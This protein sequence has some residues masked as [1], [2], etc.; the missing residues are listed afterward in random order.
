[1]CDVEW[2]ISPQTELRVANQNLTPA[3]LADRG[4]CFL[5]QG[6]NRESLQDPW[7]LCLAGLMEPH[8]LPK[9]C[10]VVVQLAWPYIYQRMLRAYNVLDPSGMMA[11][12]GEKPSSIRNRQRPTIYSNV[13]ETFL[14]RNYLICAS[15]VAPP[16]SSAALPER[17]ILKMCISNCSTACTVHVRTYVCSIYMYL[18]LYVSYRHIRTYVY[19]QSW[20]VIII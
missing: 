18:Y 12:K 7:A 1:M 5:Q 19:V 3:W 11:E 20:S 4:P 10:P 17:W 9:M 14:M 6:G 2:S 16:S 15:C 8:L 13:V